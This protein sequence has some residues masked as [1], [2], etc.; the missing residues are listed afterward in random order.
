MLCELLYRWREWWCNG[1]LQLSLQTH[2]S[3]LHHGTA[4]SSIWPQRWTDHPGKFC[5]VC[6]KPTLVRNVVM[7]SRRLVT[8]WFL[9]G[10]NAYKPF[11]DKETCSCE[12]L[13]YHVASCS[14]KLSRK[15]WYQGWPRKVKCTQ[16]KDMDAWRTE[17]NDKKLFVAF[18]FLGAWGECL[19]SQS[20]PRQEGKFCFLFVLKQC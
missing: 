14:I 9:K 8:E 7:E 5:T 2:R 1:F 18:G 4:E 3:S 17:G 20:H 6:H 11:V 19:V 15:V 16:Q 12:W 13:M 10:R